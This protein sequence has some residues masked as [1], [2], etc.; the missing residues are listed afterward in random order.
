MALTPFT[1]AKRS[2]FW[3]RPPDGSSSIRFGRLS[4][5][6]YNK[7][8]GKKQ[9]SDIIWRCYKA[10][11]Q[12]RT[13][14]TLDRLKEMGFRS[15]TKAGIS[16]GITDMIIP[17]EKS[18]QLEKAYREIAE[19]EKQYRRGIITDGERKNKVQDIWTH[20]GEELADA[21]FRTLDTTTV[22]ET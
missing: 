15:A 3:K 22:V 6:F 16:I 14:E 9:L 12:Q 20:T 10:V 17:R 5:G 8:C 2:R 13:V 19:V 18:T 21:L 7:V 11:G 4:S 1:E